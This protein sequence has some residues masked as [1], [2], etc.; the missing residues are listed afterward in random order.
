MGSGAWPPASPLRGERLPPVLTDR[1]QQ[2][3]ARQFTPLA[4]SACSRLLSTSEAMPSRTRFR[5]VHP[6]AA[7]T[8]FDCCERQHHPTKTHRRAEEPLLAGHPR[9]HSSTAMVLRKGPLPQQAHPVP[10]SINNRKPMTRVDARRAWWW[11]HFDCG[12]RPTRSRAGDPSRRTQ[13]SATAGAFA[14]VTWKS[15][16]TAWARAMKR[17]T[18]SYCESVAQVWQAFG[19]GDG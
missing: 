11:E 18:A 16:L 6:R 7:E 2:H 10:R 17:A 4:R 5:L 19:V 1:L 14:L 3:K 8:R 9:G 15:G 12:R 13:I